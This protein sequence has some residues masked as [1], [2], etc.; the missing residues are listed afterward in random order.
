[1]IGGNDLAAEVRDSSL[2]RLLPAGG[3]SFC[4]GA[5]FDVGETRIE[6]QHIGLTIPMIAYLGLFQKGFHRGGR[7]GGAANAEIPLFEALQGFSGRAAR[8]SNAAGRRGLAEVR[9]AMA[10]PLAVAI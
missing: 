6:P 7:G 10:G 2:H 9:L 8:G 4:R 1:M 5:L 3:E